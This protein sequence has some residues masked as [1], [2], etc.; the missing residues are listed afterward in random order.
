MVTRTV[1]G[2]TVRRAWTKEELVES[3]DQRLQVI[4]GVVPDLAFRLAGR[5]AFAPRCPDRFAP[6]EA[7]EPELF[8]VGSGVARCFLYD[9]GTLASLVSAAAPIR[10]DGP[11]SSAGVM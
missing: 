3:M 1:S 4:P 11:G 9:P 2:R 6:C 10:I 7:R 5:C 8:H